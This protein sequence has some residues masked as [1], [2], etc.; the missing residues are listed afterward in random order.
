[1]KALFC[2]DIQGFSK[3]IDRLSKHGFVLNESDFYKFSEY[4]SL[5]ETPKTKE[6]IGSMYLALDNQ[7][8]FSKIIIG[9]DLNLLQGAWAKSFL[10]RC[11]NLLAPG[12][13][14]ICPYVTEDFAK[15]TGSLSIPYLQSVF[16]DT[17]NES[18]AKVELSALIKEKLKNLF[19]KKSSVPFA[20]KE[21]YATFKKSSSKP[22]KDSSALDF[23]LKQKEELIQLSAGLYPDA[24]SKKEATQ[25]ALL[26][27][28]YYVGGIRYKAP[29]IK[30]IIQDYIPSS[31]KKKIIDM[32]GGYGLLCLE[33]LLDEDLNINQATNCD[34]SDLNQNLNKV[35]LSPL[36]KNRQK[37]KQ[38]SFVLT[39][40]ENHEYGK[41]NDVV[42]FIGSLLYVDR[43]LTKSTVEKAF[44]SLRPG[45]I[46]VIHENIKNPSYTADFNKMFTYEE[47]ENL[48]EEFGSIDYY[49]SFAGKRIEKNEVKN[50][51]VFRV[52]Q[53]KSA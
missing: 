48:L 44:Q 46:L 32:G 4:S 28:A 43:S 14:L 39:P 11:F 18:K 10:L 52:I 47:L 3:E 24:A 37:D 34:I 35:L 50:N 53:K 29:I 45:G 38:C 7:P 16:E 9:K 8:K 27:Q 5:L 20:V 33:L 49:S 2:R 15:K 6:D 31:S 26:Q 36:N 12:G 22:T 23:F 30:H 13:E 25:Q 19:S 42:S 40:S 1:M 41:D 17:G 51:T 21:G